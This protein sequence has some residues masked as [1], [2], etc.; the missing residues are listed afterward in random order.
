MF[1]DC[2][3][4]PHM[5]MHTHICAPFLFFQDIVWPVTCK[6]KHPFFFN[7]GISCVGHGKSPQILMAFCPLF[8]Y[9]AHRGRFW[10]Y[11][12]PFSLMG[13][14]KADFDC[15]F[16]PFYLWGPDRQILMVFCPLFTDGA[17]TGRFWWHFFPF[18]LLV[19][20]LMAFSP[21]YW[22]GSFKQRPE[23]PWLYTSCYNRSYFGKMREKMMK[24]HF[25]FYYLF[26]HAMSARKFTSREKSRF[27]WLLLY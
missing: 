22:K 18:S 21:F 19:S 23:G 26:R 5:Y 16:P 7:S 24:L 1:F 3:C 6:S 9:E 25:S 4:S 17:H 14:I 27:Y 10:W 15:I 11:F 20:I 13:P 12:A 2:I 8:T